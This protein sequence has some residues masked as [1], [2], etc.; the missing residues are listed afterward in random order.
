MLVSLMYIIGTLADLCVAAGIFVAFAVLLSVLAIGGR[1]LLSYYHQPAA[2]SARAARRNSWEEEV[3]AGIDAGDLV[4]FLLKGTL[5]WL[6]LVQGSMQLSSPL[7]IWACSV[8]LVRAARQR[9]R[10]LILLLE[11]ALSALDYVFLFAV[12]PLFGSYV[13]GIY[14]LSAAWQAYLCA[15]Y[16]WRSRSSVGAAVAVALAS[17]LISWTLGVF[18]WRQWVISAGLTP[19]PDE[20]SDAALLVTGVVVLLLIP[21]HAR[22]LLVAVGCMFSPR[23]HVLARDA[24]QLAASMAASI[25]MMQAATDASTD[26][27]AGATSVHQQAACT[28]PQ[29]TGQVCS[30]VPAGVIPSVI[31]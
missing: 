8:L 17:H 10:S 13:G 30:D 18:T 27:I 9:D 21:A 19:A 4:L 6:L 24:V 29:P 25:A 28:V 1:V 31:D 2:P 23:V 20:P 5:L 22:G 7:A 11:P 15:A 14:G 26:A 12:A 16:C 3:N